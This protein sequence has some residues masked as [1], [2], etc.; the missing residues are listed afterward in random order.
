MNSLQTVRRARGRQVSPASHATAPQLPTPHIFQPAEGDAPRDRRSLFDLKKKPGYYDAG[1]KVALLR[2]EK[3]GPL[4][5]LLVDFSRPEVNVELVAGGVPILRGDWTWQATTNGK[6]FARAGQWSE[7]CWHREEA[8]DYLEIELP[9]DNGWRLERQMLLARQERFLF[10]ADA[11]IGPGK[12]AVEI[13]YEQGLALAGEV[14]CELA[15]ET[16]EGV[17]AADGRRRAGVAPIALSEWR[18]EFCHSEL[19][20]ANGHLKLQQAAQGRSLFA[21]LWIDLDPR[22][23]K[24][25]LTWRRLSVGENLAIVQRDVA[26]GYRIQAGREQW[27]IYRSLTPFGNRSIL[28]HN[29]TYSFVCGRIKKDGAVEEVLAIE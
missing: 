14:G 16:R 3:Q 7:V 29:T 2:R 25:P 28:G 27:L 4:D 12:E 10:L 22:R 24:R 11:L 9:L 18:A 8:C 6:A 17:L 13:R 5:E 23:L 19:T 21:P 20:T 15:D 26:A 1:A